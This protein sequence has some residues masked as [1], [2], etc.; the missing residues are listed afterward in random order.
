LFDIKPNIFSVGSVAIDEWG[1][2]VM[3]TKDF[4]ALTL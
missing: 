3:G 1:V 4:G 2:V